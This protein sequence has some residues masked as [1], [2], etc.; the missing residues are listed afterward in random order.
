MLCCMSNT[1]EDFGIR[2]KILRE[3]QGL[4]QVKL[5][6]A[7]AG[8]PFGVRVKQSTLSGYESS[9]GNELPSV[10]VLAALAYVL[11]TNA[12]YLLGLT[13]DDRP[14][15]DLD[16]QVIASV[17]DPV[18]R[19]TIQEILDALVRAPVED[20]HFLAKMIRRILPAPPRRSLA[21]ST[22]MVFSPLGELQETIRLLPEERQ[23]DLLLIA[24]AFAEARADGDAERS[25]RR[26]ERS[27]LNVLERRYGTE[28]AE[29]IL[30][31][32]VSEF[33]ELDTS[34]GGPRGID[35]DIPPGK[36]DVA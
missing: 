31:L 17:A 5:A 25:Q 6:E 30:G 16:D 23:R 1:F 32:L 33:P 11:E 27:V 4:T 26:Y 28:Q 9:G 12:D 13:D 35:G 29:E 21:G 10:P 24:R 19:E 34:L 8:S 18:E 2:L 20:R 22:T 36:E 3:R 15:S 14:A 7:L